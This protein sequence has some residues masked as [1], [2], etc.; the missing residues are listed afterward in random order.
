[1][2]VER[3]LLEYLE[4][5][6]IRHVQQ[7]KDDRNDQGDAQSRSFDVRQLHIV[8]SLSFSRQRGLRLAPD[9]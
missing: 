9:D 7:G 4:K 2:Q 1:M 6:E 5:L 3:L 8:P